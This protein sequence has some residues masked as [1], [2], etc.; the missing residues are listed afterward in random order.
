MLSEKEKQEMLKGLDE[1]YARR[2][3][4]IIE[5]ENPQDYV[6]INGIR[7]RKIKGSFEDYAKTNGLI[8]AKD[9]EWSK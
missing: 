3:T 2:K 7:V 8:N 4:Y 5:N 1:V 9:I 6:I